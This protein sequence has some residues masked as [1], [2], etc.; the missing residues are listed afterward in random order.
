MNFL[1]TL[2]LLLP[3]LFNYRLAII[4]CSLLAVTVIGINIYFVA[5]FLPTLPH[6]WAMYLL[7]AII[8]LL[9]FTFIIYLVSTG[10]GGGGKG[11]EIRYICFKGSMTHLQAFEISMK[12]FL[13]VASGI[14]RILLKF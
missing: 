12:F 2:L 8:L 13:Q 9:Y 4:V 6:H 7:E 14:R 10:G 5:V 1:L 3:H 11:R